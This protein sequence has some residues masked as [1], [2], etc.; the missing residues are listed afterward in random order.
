MRHD[1]AG[2]AEMLRRLQTLPGCVGLHLCGAYLRN[3]ARKRALRDAAE[4]PD[5]ETLQILTEANRDAADWMHAQHR[6]SQW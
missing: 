1:G 2:Y 3:E 4:Q 6:S 5:A